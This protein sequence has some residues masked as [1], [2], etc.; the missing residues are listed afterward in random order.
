MDAPP[1]S[2]RRLVLAAGCLC[3]YYPTVL[4]AGAPMAKSRAP[5]FHR[6]MLGDFEIT[7]LSDGTNMLPAK[8]LLQGD[9][10]HIAQALSTANL[11]EMVE[12]SHNSYLVN[13]GPKLVLIDA[14][15]GSLLGPNVGQLVGNILA[16][17]YRPGQIDEVYLTH[18]H[19][20]HVGGLL[21]N[22]KLTFPNAIVRADKRDVGYW[23]SEDNIRAAPEAA[24][25]FF[26]SAV[27][28][29]APYQ[30]AGK[31]VTFDGDTDL[32]P[33]VRARA[34]YGHTPGHTTFLVESKG[35]KL[36]LWGDVVHVAAVQ[37]G[38][39]SIT[40]GYDV[41]AQEARQVH[42]TLF[43]DASNKRLLIG[44]AH[45]SFPGLG[46]IRRVGAGSY[47]YD[48]IPYSQGQSHS[49]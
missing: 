11:S 33:G 2:A 46:Y 43:E 3:A 44:G 8:K 20:D 29:I 1:H 49:A 5:A 10:E 40:I 42:Q 16:S 28:S 39:P 14:G 18:L 31:L 38:D 15:A 22:G 13:T 19:A 17:G 30:R 26:Q 45:I 48:P 12:T 36:L 27:A 34:A 35:E 32:I 7:A 21:T 41:E 47:A 23:L 6:F 37:F 4:L 24:K 9:L 25:R